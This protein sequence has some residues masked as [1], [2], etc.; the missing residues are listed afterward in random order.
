MMREPYKNGAYMLMDKVLKTYTRK[1]REDMC[2]SGILKP[3]GR[4]LKIGIDLV[5]VEGGYIARS[6]WNKRRRPFGYQLTVDFKEQRRQM[7]IHGK[8]PDAPCICGSSV[9]MDSYQLRQ[10]YLE[11]MKN[12]ELARIAERM[13]T[14]EK[15]ALR[16]TGHEPIVDLEALAGRAQIRDAAAFQ[17][18]SHGSALG[19]ATMRPQPQGIGGYAGERPQESMFTFLMRQKYIGRHQRATIARQNREFEAWKENNLDQAHED[20]REAEG[21]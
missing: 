6:E 5:K 10:A 2:F 21:I 16:A 8:R 13:K 19:I 4:A 3:E 14:V 12:R 18:A 17:K 7:C 15:D 20:F 9:H 11:R 1:E